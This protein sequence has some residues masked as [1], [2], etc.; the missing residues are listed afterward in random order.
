MRVVAAKNPDQIAPDGAADADVVHLEDFFL[1]PDDR[2]LRYSLAVL[3]G[4]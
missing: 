2:F 1:C 3:L 4:Q